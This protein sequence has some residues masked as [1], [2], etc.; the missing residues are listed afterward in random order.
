MLLRETACTCSRTHRPLVR[1]VRIAVPLPR[2]VP[3]P[4]ILPRTLWLTPLPSG[5]RAVVGQII[6]DP[7]QAWN[8]ILHND[9]T[10][11]M[12]AYSAWLAH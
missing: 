11:F 2:R 7:Q 5:L 10:R 12:A 8:E 3:L 1:Q 6:G 4:R 9:H